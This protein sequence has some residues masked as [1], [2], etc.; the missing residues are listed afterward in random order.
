MITAD[1]QRPRHLQI[2]KR[3]GY[4]E[5]FQRIAPSPSLPSSLSPSAQP[6]EGFRQVFRFPWQLQPPFPP[7]QAATPLSSFLPN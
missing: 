1:P 4:Q 3:D 7:S 5:G 2:S 6:Q